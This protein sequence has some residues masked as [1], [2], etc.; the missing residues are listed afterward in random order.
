MRNRRRALA[1]IMVAALCAPGTWLRTGA[2][3]RP[4]QNI[5]I[6]QVQAASASDDLAWSVAGVWHYSADSL[7]FGGFSALI[8]LEDG[9]LRAFSDRGGRFTFGAPDRP[10]RPSE[11]TMQSVPLDRL[12]D[13][14]DIEAAASD[15]ATGRYWLAVEQTHAVIRYDDTGN[16]DGVRNL[17]TGALD[18]SVNSGAEAMTR[19]RDGR[20]LILPEGRRTGI[21][22]ASDPAEGAAQQTFAYLPPVP[23][24]ATTDIAQLPDGRVLLLLRNLDPGGGMPPFQSKLA[25]GPPPVADQ[26]EP[27]AP[28]VVLDLAGVIP[29]ENY[30]GLAVREME[31]GRAAIWLISDNNMSLIQRTLLAKLVFDP[32]AE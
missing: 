24:H 17:E 1:A 8:T 10:A 6:E 9:G 20:F 11:V 16:P 3:E 26:S 14:I 5:A 28:E 25:L 27:W 21:V 4:P 31:D 22:F 32:A 15:P 7:L 18:W 13:L 12:D 19:L 23:G 29:R 30:E 2:L